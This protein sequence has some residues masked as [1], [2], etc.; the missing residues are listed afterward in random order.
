MF[1]NPQDKIINLYYYIQKSL[2]KEKIANPAE[3]LCNK[4]SISIR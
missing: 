3:D 1:A 2:K 4:T